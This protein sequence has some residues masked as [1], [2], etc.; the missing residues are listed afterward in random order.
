MLGSAVHATSRAPRDSTHVG[1]EQQQQQLHHDAVCIV[2]V[3]N[4]QPSI[5]AAQ[6]QGQQQMMPTV[7]CVYKPHKRVCWCCMNSKGKLNGQQKGAAP[8]LLHAVGADHSTNAR[9]A[10][11]KG[12]NVVCTCGHR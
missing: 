10:T 11:V 12:A 8:R 4:V 9:C 2:P 7:C 1:E 6:L 5:A 3:G